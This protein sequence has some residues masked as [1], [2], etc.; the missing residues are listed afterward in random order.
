MKTHSDV[1]RPYAGDNQ[2]ALAINPYH[3]GFMMWDHIV[4]DQGVDAALR[5]RREEDD[6]SF[7]RNYLDTALAKELDLFVYTARRSGEV[8]V[9]EADI[10]TLH[11]ALLVSKY[12]FGAPRIAVDEV[13][14]DGALVLRHE[15]QV[16]GRGLDIER[17]RKVLAYIHAVW[18]RPVLLYTVDGRGE[19]QCL[20]HG[21]GQ[22]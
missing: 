7:V 9:T 14:P 20:G 15:H 16:D 4:K 2:V 19:T 3:L 12:N 11:E 8:Q 18:H 6:F 13:R 10:A 22:M 21:H 17:T 1:V 5:I